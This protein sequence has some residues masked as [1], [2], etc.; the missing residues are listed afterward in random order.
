MLPRP[1]GRNSSFNFLFLLSM[2]L[3]TALN[4][5]LP[6]QGATQSR[7]QLVAFGLRLAAGSTLSPSSYEQQLLDQFAQGNLTL[8]QVAA[9]LEQLTNDWECVYTG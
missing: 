6:N 8:E 7:Q 4:V 1:A 9:E 5:T 2:H 3:A